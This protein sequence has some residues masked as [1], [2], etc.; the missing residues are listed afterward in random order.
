MQ[1]SAKSKKRVQFSFHPVK[2]FIIYIISILF[3]M[4]F[5]VER[6]LDFFNRYWL[7]MLREMEELANYPFLFFFGFFIGPYLFCRLY[8]HFCLN[9]EEKRRISEWQIMDVRDYILLWCSLY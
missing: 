7:S 2:A 5:S 4:F 6:F 8:H 9:I 1:G 3:D